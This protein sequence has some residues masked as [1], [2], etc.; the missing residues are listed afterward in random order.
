M[1][2]IKGW[3][4]IKLKINFYQKY[5]ITGMVG[6]ILCIGIGVVSFNY[7]LE[8]MFNQ[9]LT[10]Y[11]ENDLI[12]F[13][14]IRYELYNKRGEEFDSFLRTPFDMLKL[15]KPPRVIY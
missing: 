2:G 8:K 7:H 1:E 13:D 15:R 6:I 10:Y 11:H 9:A 4:A 3:K 12:S 14:E 5:I